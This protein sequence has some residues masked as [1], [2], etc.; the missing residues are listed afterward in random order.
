MDNEYKPESKKEEPKV[1]DK[2]PKAPKASKAPK[3]AKSFT[4]K[5]APRRKRLRAEKPDSL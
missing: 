1:S 5:P 3:A 4:P 2:A